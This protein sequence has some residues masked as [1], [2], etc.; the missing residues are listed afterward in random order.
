MIP[1]APA[2]HDEASERSWERTLE[3]FRGK[4]QGAAV[5]A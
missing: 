1:G 5:D 2:H 3:L 4:L